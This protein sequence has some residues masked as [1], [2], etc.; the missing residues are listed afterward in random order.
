MHFICPPKFC[1]PFVFHFSWVLQASQ[2]K[3]KTVPMQIVSFL[4]GDGGWGTK[5][6]GGGQIRCI[7]G[8]V[9]VAN[10][11]RCKKLYINR[12]LTPDKPAG[13]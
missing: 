1:V 11:E 13:N 6:G 12:F 4:A 2:E 8:D 5:G 9:H 10:E 7:M 3:L